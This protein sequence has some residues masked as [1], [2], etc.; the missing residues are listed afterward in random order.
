MRVRLEL[1]RFLLRRGA[2]DKAA[3]LLAAPGP[4]GLADPETVALQARAMV[5]SGRALD[6]LNVVDAALARS[7]GAAPLTFVKGF[8]QEQ[9]G[10]PVEAE[11]LYR[12]AA[13]QAPGDW[14]PHLGL[15]RLALKA[16]DLPKAAASLKLAGRRP[17]DRPRSRWP[18]DLE[19]AQKNVAAAAARAW[20]PT[21]PARYGLARAALGRGGG[22]VVAE[23]ERAR[24][25]T[26]ACAA[27]WRWPAS[28]KAATSLR[29]EGLRGAVALD[30]GARARPGA[31]RRGG[32]GSG[33]AER[34][35]RTWRPP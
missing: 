15:G 11:A 6:A 2:A 27:S 22:A 23:L 12:Q 26:R 25:S 9:L 35:C 29:Q 3:A 33:R 28:S 34:R 10:K 31:A 19:L 7:P 5:L 1:A 24:R 32:A 16:N 18:R 17:R 4:G 21:S 14:E 13:A 20:R 8:I 30:P